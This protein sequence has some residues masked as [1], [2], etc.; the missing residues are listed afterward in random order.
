MASPSKNEGETLKKVI[1][2]TPINLVPKAL[3]PLRFL[4]GVVKKTLEPF[5]IR[6]WL[7]FSRKGKKGKGETSGGDTFTATAVTVHGHHNW[8]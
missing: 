2:V 6:W 3:V 5:A 4:D 7:P 1:S 8:T